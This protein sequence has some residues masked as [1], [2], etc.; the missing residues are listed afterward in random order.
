LYQVKLGFVVSEFNEE[1]TNNMLEEA[2]L[3]ASKL[4]AVIN[5]VCYVPG[6]FDMPLMI[7]SLIKKI[8]VD[9][10]VTLGA[11]I[12][13]D[14]D[15]DIIVAENA[16]RIIADLSLK[17]NKPIVL[18]ISGPNMTLN[19]A[20]ERVKIVPIRTVNAAVNMV[21]RLQK[22]NGINEM[23]NKMTIIK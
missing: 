20:L 14:T 9:A 5:Y 18:G 19:Q 10:I 21:T 1:I 16:A 22:I 3:Q 23:E 6:T 17:H 11:V 7:N 2:K 8:N 13:G 12:K 15:H 4:G